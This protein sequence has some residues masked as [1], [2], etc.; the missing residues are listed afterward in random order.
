MPTS[1]VVRLDDLRVR[2]EQRLHRCLALHRTDAERLKIMEH[3]AGVSRL[4]GSDR[5][6]AVW[7][8]EYGPGLVHPHVVLDLISDTPRRRFSADPLRMAWN[9]GVPGKLDLP[10]VDRSGPIPIHDTARSLCAVALGSDGAKAW[11]LVADGL[12]TRLP[13][14]RETSGAL[15]FLA[16]ECAGVLLHRDLPAGTRGRPRQRFAGW[17]VLRD[18]EGREEDEATNRRIGGRFLVARQLRALVDDDFAVDVGTLSQQ[19]QAISRELT[20]VPRE[21]P[22]R[23]LWE[24]VLRELDR[25]DWRELAAATLA[26]AGHV[27]GQ[28]HTHGARELYGLAHVTAVTAG[29]PTE[30]AE[31]ARLLGRLLRNRGEWDEAIRWYE[32]ARAVAQ[33][34]GDR[35]LE[36][37]V[38]DGLAS[39]VRDRGNL[40]GARALLHEGLVAA[41][42]SGDDYALASV[43]DTL[44]IVEMLSGRLPH[45][46][47]HGWRAVNL[48]R[49]D[50]R[51]NALVSLAGCFFGMGELGAAEDSYA[52]VLK[53]V[54]R[55]DNQYVAVEMLAHL[56]ALRGDRKQFDEWIER[57]N[58]SGW[59]ELVSPRVYAQTLQY[60]GL[61][62]QALG[63]RAAA[64][65]W[66]ERARDY[67][68]EHAV[69]QVFFD[70]ETSL[71]ELESTGA[72]PAHASRDAAEA[73]PGD[74]GPAPA[75]LA[76]IRIGVGVL[77][78]EL[79]PV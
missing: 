13:L 31:G 46:V 7:I 77:R 42:E 43:H 4:L 65:T 69:N 66:L 41:Q 68:Q 32:G 10:D 19:L 36:A 16:G 8:D 21:D 61:S 53:R 22:E 18:I 58:M 67:A 26:L 29:A 48:H 76:E 28:G 27:E 51:Y 30:A 24:D 5:V 25:G 3:L 52:I 79:A 64:R 56:A 75:E 14:D 15:M 45:A 78:R 47:A 9:D 62:W 44:M 37:V 55:P 59:R 6:A 40:P 63:D 34:E 2:R 73:A 39:A 17:P 38:L 49:E 72:T 33:V 71:A 23:G 70:S 57:Q 60:R 74:P 50:E 12:N 11:F 20:R 1:N 54:A 35:R